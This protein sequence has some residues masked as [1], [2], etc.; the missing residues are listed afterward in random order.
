[1]IFSGEAGS[2]VVLAGASIGAVWA[3]RNCDFV[4]DKIQE[5]GFGVFPAC[6]TF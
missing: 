3:Q 4:D 2:K 5:F 1:M 6:F